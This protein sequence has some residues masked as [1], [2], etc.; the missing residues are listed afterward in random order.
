MKFVTFENKK[1]FCY[2][3]VENTQQNWEKLIKI[4]F[5]E[6]CSFETKEILEHETTPKMQHFLTHFYNPYTKCSSSSL[7]IYTFLHAEPT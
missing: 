6:E 7:K 4:I 5:H 3:F 2:F 1:V